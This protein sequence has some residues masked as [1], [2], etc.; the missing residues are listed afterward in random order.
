MRCFS[1][2]Y[3]GITALLGLAPC[4]GACSSEYSIN[5]PHPENLWQGPS[6]FNY[7]GHAEEFALGPPGPAELV[8]ADGH[9]AARAQATPS[10]AAEQQPALGQGGIALQ[11]TECQVVRREGAPERV[12]LGKTPAG[13]R[14]V[15]LTYSGGSRPGIYHFA[16]GR[17][18]SIERAPEPPQQPKTAQAK[19]KS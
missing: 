6:W 8:D 3:V 14:S 19:K 7:S 15:V 11:M 17:L 18:V 1:R 16:G 2:Y 5:L 9:C 4:L 12:E 13:E 10:D